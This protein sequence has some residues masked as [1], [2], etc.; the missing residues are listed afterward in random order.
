MQ[1]RWKFLWMAVDTDATCQICTDKAMFPSYTPTN[2]ELFMRNSS[3]S[4]IE[5]QHKIVLK[6]TSRNELTLNNVRHVPKIRKNLVSDSLLSKNSFKLIFI[7]HKFILAKN[8]MYVGK[9]YVSNGL[10]KIKCP[11]HCT[12]YF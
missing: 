3:S 6:M 5:G 11:H 7:S 10:F 12:Q 1:Q 2:G 4:K 9:S 8:N